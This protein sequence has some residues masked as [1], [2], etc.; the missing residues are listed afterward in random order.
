MSVIPLTHR[1]CSYN[2]TAYFQDNIAILESF[3][4][5]NLNSKGLVTVKII[6][7][8]DKYVCP[9]DSFYVTQ[10]DCAI[11][12]CLFSL[13]QKCQAVCI[14]SSDIGDCDLLFFPNLLYKWYQFI[15]ASQSS[16]AI[17]SLT[18]RNLLLH[19]DYLVMNA[20]LFVSTV[21]T[22]SSSKM[23]SVT[24]F[25]K[26]TTN[27]YSFI[28]KVCVA[29]SIPHGIIRNKNVTLEVCL[30]SE[31]NKAESSIWSMAASVFS[32][33]A[34]WKQ[35]HFQQVMR[36]AKQAFVSDNIQIYW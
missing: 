6:N 10:N 35:I 25:V 19:N 26:D 12:I 11:E 20:A 7:I 30:I 29:W 34:M 28:E 16:H 23:I 33:S 24:V 8:C 36:S 1:C 17:G 32:F 14:D 5:K 18:I 31:D 27:L 13:L 15:D 21:V 2:K 3:Q 9:Q 22:T 4:R